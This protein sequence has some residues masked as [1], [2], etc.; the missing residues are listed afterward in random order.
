[1]RKTSLICM[2][3][4]LL[5]LTALQGCSSGDEGITVEDDWAAVGLT[6]TRDASMRDDATVIGQFERNGIKLRVI[7]I[8]RRF[9]EAK[10]WQQSVPVSHVPMEQLPEAIKEKVYMW[11]MS[12]LTKLFR[13]EYNGKTYYDINSF[14]SSSMFNLFD[15]EGNPFASSDDLEK[16]TSESTATCILVLNVE[17]IKNA[18]DAPNYLVGIWQNDWQ[19]LIQGFEKEQAIVELYPNLPFS[20]TE[21]IRFRE[22]GTGYL[23]TIKEYKDGQKDITLDPF[24]YELTDYHGGDS[25]GY[26]AYSYL[27]HF[28][29]GDDI[30]F[31]SRMN[32]SKQVIV[33]YNAWV[34]YP[35]FRQTKDDY[36]SLEVNAGQKYGVPAKDNANPIVGRWTGSDTSDALMN[37]VTTTW[38]FRSDSTGYLLLDQRFSEPFVY[39]IDY[40]G[41]EAELT[42]YKYNTGFAVSDGFANDTA[43][44]VFDPTILPQ[45]MT[46]KATFKN[47]TLELE[48]WG[49]N[50]QREK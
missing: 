6:L 47:D 41:S 24:N 32:D 22:D 38:V 30:E 5:L 17:T 2:A 36:E 23:R 33:P 7:D 27:C 9:T 15:S 48:G 3:A 26:H 42:I 21:V 4:M 1:M 10:Y 39:T 40:Q 43:H 29:A 12:S 37:T 11:G 25:Y 20:I 8:T 16:I 49:A 13:L 28:E 18:D 34:N 35:W 19:H 14:L 31:S 45:G 50:Y 46:I 44:T